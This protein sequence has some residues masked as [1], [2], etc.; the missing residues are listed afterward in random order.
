MDLFFSERY[1]ENFFCYIFSFQAH[2]HHYTQVDGMEVSEFS[3]SFDSLNEL[4]N[5]YE[6]LEK[7]MHHPPA[8]VPRLQI[9]T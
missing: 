5:E 4:I 6:T 7:Q 8:A 3:E 2:I 9:A 1:L